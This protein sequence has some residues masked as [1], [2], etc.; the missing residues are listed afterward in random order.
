M[1]MTFRFKIIFAKKNIFSTDPEVVSKK[2]HEKFYSQ[3]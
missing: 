3:S 2:I 1:K